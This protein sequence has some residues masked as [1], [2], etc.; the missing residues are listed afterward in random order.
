MSKMFIIDQG[1]ILSY[2]R[3]LDRERQRI[4]TEVQSL[5]NLGD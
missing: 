5:L 3:Y 4:L 1:Q 2:S